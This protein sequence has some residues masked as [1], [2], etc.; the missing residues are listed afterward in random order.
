MLHNGQIEG[1]SEDFKYEK[2]CGCKDE[3]IEG[4]RVKGWSS[5]KMDSYKEISL[6]N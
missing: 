4:F 5:L 1:C 3:W 2:T 6:R